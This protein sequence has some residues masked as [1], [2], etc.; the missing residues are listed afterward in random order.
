M[1]DN[2]DGRVTCV[3]KC[4]N[5]ADVEMLWPY[6][7]D[8]I[9]AAVE[10]TRL[11][12]LG[13]V[14][15]DLFNGSALLWIVWNGDVVMAAAATQIVVAN[16]EKYCDIT[17]CGGHDSKQWLPLIAGIEAYAKREG[18]R[19]MRIFGRKGWKRMLPDYHVVGFILERTL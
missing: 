3:L 5:P 16:G 12:D 17:V 7:N 4:I 10:K 15:R 2:H 9:E 19:A 11:S 6:V 18:C 14:Q 13:V 8:L 1:N